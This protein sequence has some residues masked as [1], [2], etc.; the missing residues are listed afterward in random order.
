MLPRP[1]VLTLEWT[2]TFQRLSL[3]T[4]PPPSTTAISPASRSAAATTTSGRRRSHRRASLQSN[5]HHKLTHVALQPLLLTPSF[6]ATEQQRQWRQ[7]CHWLSAS[8]RHAYSTSISATPTRRTSLSGRSVFAPSSLVSPQPS[9]AS[10]LRM[11]LH[12][13]WI[14]QH[15][16]PQVGKTWLPCSRDCPLDRRRHSSL[17]CMPTSSRRLLCPP[18]LARSSCTTRPF[19]W[20][21]RHPSKR[22]F[23]TF[24]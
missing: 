14:A 20:H 17:L 23:L 16:P 19:N 4:T 6:C 11:L 18:H 15:L 22:P 7:S 2:S 8:S 5:V 1:S 24:L 13:P 3:N 21:T 12:V 9:L 10:K